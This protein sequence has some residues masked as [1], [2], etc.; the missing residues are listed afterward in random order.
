MGRRLNAETEAAIKVV[1][2]VLETGPVHDPR[3][4]RTSTLIASAAEIS[5][6]MASHALMWLDKHGEIR[7][8]IDGRRCFAVRMLTQEE[9]IERAQNPRLRV[10]PNRP[11]EVAQ[12]PVEP[13]GPS[14]VLRIVGEVVATYRESTAT[15]AQALP[16]EVNHAEL[17]A[18]ILRLALDAAAGPQRQAAELRDARAR[19]ATQMEEAQRL[20]RKYGE[21]Q[22]VYN[23]TI[24]ERDGLRERARHAQQNLDRVLRGGMLDV[25]RERE[26][27]LIMQSMRAPDASSRARDDQHPSMAARR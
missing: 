18:E 1:R 5:V 20:R 7:R 14:A 27:K 25:E 19:L 13:S 4:G 10:V 8:E 17:A 12:C 11:A 24:H 16:P 22:D 3:F 26:L 6:D 23:A 15:P 21:L 2:E 9:R